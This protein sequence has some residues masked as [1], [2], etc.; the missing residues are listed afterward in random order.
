MLC[1]SFGPAATFRV[2]RSLLKRVVGAHLQCYLVAASV[3]ERDA[4][5][6]ANAAD[7]E[8]RAGWSL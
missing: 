1:K 4:S 5:L 7:V 8:E 2:R 6:N 3:S